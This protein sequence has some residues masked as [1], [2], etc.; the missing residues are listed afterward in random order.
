MPPMPVR[1]DAILLVSFGGPEGIDDVLPFLAN[2]VRGK[3]VPEE[4]VRAVARNYEQFGGKSPLPEQCRALVAAISAGARAARPAAAGLLGQPQLAPVPRRHAAADGRGRRDPRARAL[5]VGLRLVPGLPPVSRGRRA[6]AARGRRARPTGRQAARVLQPPWLRGAAGG[7]R[8]GGL[9]GGPGGAPRG[10]AARVHGPQPAARD[11][12]PHATTPPSCARRRRS[13][14]D[15][16]GARGTRSR[17]R[18]AAAGP[19]SPGSS[20]TSSST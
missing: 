9:R 8:G 5:H 19:A 14:R 15:R 17:T 11:G 10:R 18:A 12:R 3:D 20:P 2:V 6:R 1:Y 16:S 13:W 7:A 4:R